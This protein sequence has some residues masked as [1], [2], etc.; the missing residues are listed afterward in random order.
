MYG[1]YNMNNNYE[2]NKISDNKVNRTVQWGSQLAFSYTQI[3]S[4]YTQKLIDAYN[5]SLMLERDWQKLS[6]S[7]EALSEI[8]PDYFQTSL[9]MFA[10]K[11]FTLE[12]TRNAYLEYVRGLDEKG[13]EELIGQVKKVVQDRANAFNNS[14]PELRNE[15]VKQEILNIFGKPVLGSIYSELYG[16]YVQSLTEEEK[17]TLA[18]CDTE[19]A[20]LDSV[21]RTRRTGED[22]FEQVHELQIESVKRD[23]FSSTEIPFIISSIEKASVIASNELKKMDIVD[24]L[25]SHHRLV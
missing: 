18:T 13:L 20:L 25:D 15:D 21:R 23:G 17:Q 8:R 24:Q 6:H 16:L 7:S 14:V 3:A 4:D 1:G 9:K 22:K 2:N 12:Q 10:I 5:S 11:A 19:K